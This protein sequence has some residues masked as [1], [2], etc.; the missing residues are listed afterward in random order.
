M[1]VLLLPLLF[2]AAA[3]FRMAV[4]RPALVRRSNGARSMTAVFDALA[5]IEN[6]APSARNDGPP[7]TCS[8]QPAQL[9]LTSHQQ[10]VDARGSG[11]DEAGHVQGVHSRG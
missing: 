6:T 1:R 10:L 3:A 8:R 5:G 2:V 4:P 11:G 9:Q 7:R